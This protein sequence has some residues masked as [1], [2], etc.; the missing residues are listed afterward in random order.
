MR[1]LLT[2]TALMAG[3]MVAGLA[4]EQTGS[5]HGHV[6]SPIGIAITDATVQ[7]STD[8]KDAKY[9]F[10]TDANGDFKG[11]GIAPGTYFLNLY[12][13]TKPIDQLA[14]VKIVAGQDEL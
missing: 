11:D 2:V 13:G 12:Q 6:T 5:I 14:N 10:N 1:R 4:Q 7:V 9:K 8:G 3:S